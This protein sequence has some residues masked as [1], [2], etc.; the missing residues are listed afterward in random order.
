MKKHNVFSKLLKFSNL[1]VLA[2]IFFSCK[3][4]PVAPGINEV[5]PMDLLD[6]KSAFYI[7][8]PSKADPELISRVIKNNVPSLSLNDAKMIG[9]RVQTVY[10]GLSHKKNLTQVQAAAKC[11][12]P[13]KYIPK[14]LNSKN[15]W[16]SES[17]SAVNG[18]LPYTIYSSNS[19]DLCFPASSRM[20]LGRDLT[21]MIDRYDELAWTPKGL[22]DDEDTN[23]NSVLDKDI[24]EYL[25]G[26]DDEIRFFANQPQ[27]FLSILMGST[28]DLKLINVN[29]RMVV[30][31]KH[32]EQY[33]VDI[34]FEFKSAAIL[35]AGKVLLKVAFGLT[36]ADSMDLSPTTLSIKNIKLSK[37]QLYS[38]LLI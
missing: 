18:P 12:V 25:K 7:A 31:E 9:E 26:A 32:P 38:L 3:T 35:K 34:N 22:T 24:Y 27:A 14:A 4:M 1:I 29:G 19:I 8:V 21:S 6:D 37:T 11:D 20:L 5:H 17:Y 10:L 30:D 33:L 28:L 16:K 36:D 15:G 2:G 13:L 23:L